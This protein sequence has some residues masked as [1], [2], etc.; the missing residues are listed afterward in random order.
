MVLIKR[1]GDSLF[2]P[3]DVLQYRVDKKIVTFLYFLLLS[4]LLMVPNFISF[5]SDT[6]FFT[7]EV[8][9]NIRYDVFNQEEVP[10]E[11]V[12]GKLTFTGTSEKSQYVINVSTYEVT[13]IFTTQDS[14]VQDD[15]MY[16]NIIVF[17][18]DKVELKNR[19]N[20]MELGRYSDYASSEGLDLKY[21]TTS[22]RLF[23]EQAFDL[24]SEFEEGYHSLYVTA[25]TFFIIFRSIGTLFLFILF[26]TFINRI[27]AENIYSFGDHLKL[28]I[29]YSTPFV[30]G[31]IFATLF[32]LV[33]IEYIG[34]I[35]TFI[36][37]LR[38]NHI[39]ITGGK[40][41]EL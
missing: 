1:L 12:D 34:L 3:K 8:K 17:S 40:D 7:Y 31:V 39:E 21:L 37:S 28:M 26:I 29:Y 35:I 16:R 4:V 15:N 32:D 19:F 18:K 5:F 11:I 41:N 27:S 2:S 20:K 22:D 23:W 6:S 9:T 36:Y 13:L 30:F 24:F 25:I 14:I 38:I 33:L 10:Y